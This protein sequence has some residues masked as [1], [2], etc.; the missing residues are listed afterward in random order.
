M[1]MR[2]ISVYID[3]MIYIYI[4][5]KIGDYVYRY[6]DVMK[7]IEYVETFVKEELEKSEEIQVEKVFRKLFAQ[8]SVEVSDE[9]ILDVSRF[10]RDK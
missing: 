1:R 8:K 9:L 10:F 6:Q 2:H 4:G 3:C 7:R 5:G